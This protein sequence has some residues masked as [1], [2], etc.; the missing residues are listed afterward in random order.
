MIGI[1]DSG[2]GGLTVL[3]AIRARAPRADVVYFGDLENAPYGNKS[4]EELGVLT[5]LGIQRLI[6]AGATELVSACNSVSVSIVLPMFDILDLSRTSLIE[7]V[8]PTVAAFRGT[9]ARVL[10]V[11]TRATVESRIYQDAFRMIGI[12]ADGVA[13]PDLVPHIE[14]GGSRSA[15]APL[16]H[17]ALSPYA[18]GNYTH[19]ILG[20]T[21]FPLVRDVFEEAL[22]QQDWRGVLVDPADAVAD[23]VT[24]RFDTD[25]SGTVDLMVSAESS[26]FLGFAQACLGA[27]AA[28]RVV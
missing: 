9:T 17:A 20:C 12:P 24:A 28:P 15:M 4:R 13:I 6:G 26:V 27:S 14:G 11:A 25:G 5:V 3:R 22:S 7:M 23:A 10:V 16:V 21:H 2:S 18:H 8:G 1:F 19:V